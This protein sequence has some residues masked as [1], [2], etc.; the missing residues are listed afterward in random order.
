VQIGPAADHA[1]VGG[2]PVAA[3]VAV[4]AGVHRLVQVADEVDQEG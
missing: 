4:V 1:I 2:D 3:E